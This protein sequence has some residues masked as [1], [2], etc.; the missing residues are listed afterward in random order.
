MS[1]IYA[2]VLGWTQQTGQLIEF[3]LGYRSQYTRMESFILPSVEWV[4][5]VVGDQFPY[6]WTEDM[7]AK[8]AAARLEDYADRVNRLADRFNLPVVPLG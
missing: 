1:A 7:K 3:E 8:I 2:G 6:V 5:A 4:H